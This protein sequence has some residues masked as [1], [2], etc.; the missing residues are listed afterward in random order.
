MIQ[1][2]GNSLNPFLNTELKTMRI[3]PSIHQEEKK[4]LNLN[5]LFIIFTPYHSEEVG[6]GTLKEL[7]SIL[8]V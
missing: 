8:G 7:N 5:F 4:G 3:D 2:Y 6:D 1:I